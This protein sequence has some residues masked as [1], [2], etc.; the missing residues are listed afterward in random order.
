[1]SA[2]CFACQVAEK[3]PATTLRGPAGCLSCDA[4]TLALIYGGMTH[5]AISAAMHA[6]WP[7]TKSFTKGRALFWSWV[8]KIEEAKTNQGAA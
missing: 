1:M 2:P 6:T 3:H 8:R 7:D 5:A 4:R